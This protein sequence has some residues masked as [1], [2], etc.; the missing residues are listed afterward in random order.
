MLVQYLFIEKFVIRKVKN[1]IYMKK[2]VSM[3]IIFISLFTISFAH[4][5]KTD[6]NGGHY[7]SSTGEYHYHHGYPAHQHNAD[8]SCP[9]EVNLVI[10]DTTENNNSEEIYKIEGNT[11]EYYKNKTNELESK[12]EN[13]ESEINSKDSKITELEDEI[14]N[15]NSNNKSEEETLNIA[16]IFIIIVLICILYFNNKNKKEQLKDYKELENIIRNELKTK[17][18]QDTINTVKDFYNNQK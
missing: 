15:I 14:E 18:L 17:D 8:G 1:N 12:V 11:E 4:S 10:N 3:L 9:Y 7:D 16:Y 6:S 13:L 2:A 5:G